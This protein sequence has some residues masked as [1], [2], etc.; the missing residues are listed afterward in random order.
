MAYKAHRL[1]AGP[2]GWAVMLTLFSP[3]GQKTLVKR[4]LTKARAKEIASQ[5]NQ[6]IGY[7][8]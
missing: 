8:E 4:N 2:M 5:F 7:V 6:E 3:N 1:K